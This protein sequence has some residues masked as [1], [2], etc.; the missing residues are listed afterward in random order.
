M[1]NLSGDRGGTGGGGGGGVGKGGG[2]RKRAHP[3][4]K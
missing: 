4:T 2:E 1:G 3:L